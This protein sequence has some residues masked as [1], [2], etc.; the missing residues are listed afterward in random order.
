MSDLD[1]AYLIQRLDL[2]SSV[3]GG[4]QGGGIFLS[5]VLDWNVARGRLVG[6]KHKGGCYQ[7]ITHDGNPWEL[8]LEGRAETLHYPITDP[9]WSKSQLTQK[10]RSVV[11]ASF[12]DLQL[13]GGFCLLDSGL[14]VVRMYL[15]IDVSASDIKHEGACWRAAGTSVEDVPIYGVV[16]TPCFQLAPS[17]PHGCCLAPVKPFRM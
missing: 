4:V 5:K 14:L 15:F 11:D 16:F 3:R 9:S 2:A 6:R 17:F 1:I 12:H 7:E 10:Y 8:C 13:T